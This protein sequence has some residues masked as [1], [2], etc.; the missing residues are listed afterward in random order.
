MR[1]KAA[2]DDG[3][4]RA[5]A[6]GPSAPRRGPIEGM[7]AGWSAGVRTRLDPGRGAQALRH[8]VYASPLYRLTLG[9]R[10]PAEVRGLPPDPWPGEPKAAHA[11]LEGAWMVRGRRRQ[12][13]DNPWRQA[14]GGDADLHGFAWL[15]DLRALGSQAA[16]ARARRLVGDWIT[17]HA[18]WS[19]PA[20]RPDVLGRR[21]SNWLAAYAFLSAGADE[22]FRARLLGALATQARHLRRS[23]ASGPGDGRVFTA[24]KGLIHCGAC[25]PGFEAC[26][27][28]GLRLLA[29][30]LERQVLPD[31]GHFQRSPALQLKV[32]GHLIDIRAALAGARREVPLALQSAIDRMTPMLRALRLGD[33][34]LAL[35]NGGAEED[36][37]FIDSVLAQTGVKGQPLSSAPHS[38]FQ[39]LAAGRTVIVVDAGSPPAAGAAA[40]AGCL[41][42]E[43]SSGRN[44]LVV[45]CGPYPGD[46]AAW[47]AATR[48]TAS[49]STLSVDDTS[50]AG[51][52][53][54]GEICRGPADVGAQRRQAEGNIWLELS[55]D[56]YRRA[57]GLIHR[58]RLYL[59][60]S[61]EDFRG[62]DHLSGA[63]GSAFAV[64]FHLHPLVQASL[65]QDRATVLLKPLRGRGWRL[66]AS[67]GALGLEESVYFGAGE[68]RRTDQIVITG[69][70]NGKGALI[71]WR[72]SR[73]GA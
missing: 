26:L 20:W 37:A 4:G 3:L 66:Q 63:G 18:T 2:V 51:F 36:G 61:G 30:Q 6:P 25:L 54:A 64:R 48:S 41:S 70:L 32:L 33:G 57:F 55:H 17:A 5:D 72:L 1:R 52:A 73:A 34:G 9:G 46:D 43:M 27:G 58:R 59:D 67:G 14:A 31:G 60:S 39:R 12:W 71:K 56:G 40:H 28:E 68:R 45:N 11:I 38:G 13:G 49:H 19:T 44:R 47:R 62:E 15:G 50:S 29:R 10:P 8:L 16:R 7:L 24:I 53:P 22:A 69:P 35:F 42:F 23:A 21:L 65:S